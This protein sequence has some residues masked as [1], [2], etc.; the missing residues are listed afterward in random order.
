[1]AFHEGKDGVLVSGEFVR[2]A[3][4][5][6]QEMDAFIKHLRTLQT[7][8]GLEGFVYAVNEKNGKII[9]DVIPA[10]EKLGD[11]P[12]PQQPT[13]SKKI[14]LTATADASIKDELSGTVAKAAPKSS[15]PT[16]L[17]P[18]STSGVGPTKKKRTK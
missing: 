5:F 7:T 12:E 10:A 3:P 13:P 1:M 17:A 11:K 9:I 8:L 14:S 2:D 6:E 15:R 18:P 4:A 16:G